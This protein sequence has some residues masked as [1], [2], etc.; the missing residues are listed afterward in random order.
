LDE[1]RQNV[2]SS[3]RIIALSVFV[4]L[5]VLLAGCSALQGSE[6]TTA[7]LLLANQDGEAHAVVVEI[8]DGESE[9][10]ATG[11]TVDAESD[12]DLRTFDQS[13]EYDV[14]VTVDGT[15]TTLTQNF[16]TGR[17]TTTIG[18]EN[19]GSVTVGA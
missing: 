13:G 1:R 16:D 19:D 8:L 18:I 3:K 5:L 14:V 17:S 10:Y 7:N 2:T 11:Q 9:V 6:D 15:S 12:V 4:A